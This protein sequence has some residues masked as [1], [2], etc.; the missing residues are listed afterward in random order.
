MGWQRGIGLKR[1]K[2]EEKF[3]EVAQLLIQE[4][5]LPHRQAFQA[6]LTNDASSSCG[7]SAG[8]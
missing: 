2:D 3:K 5:D 7:K 1:G 6:P 8:S 4:V